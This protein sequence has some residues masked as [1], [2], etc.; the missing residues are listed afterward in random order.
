MV[1]DDSQQIRSTLQGFSA[2]LADM[3]S[4]C[5]VM[6]LQQQLD[7]ADGRVA[8]AQESFVTPLTQ[9]EHTAAVST[10]TDWLVD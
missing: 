4:V 6:A 10:G 2:V 7:E 5:D 1:L 3:A 9:L 8:A